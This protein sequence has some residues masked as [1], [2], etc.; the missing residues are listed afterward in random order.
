MSDTDWGI[1]VPAVSVSTK[2]RQTREMKRQG[3]DV[4]MYSVLG[5]RP[6]QQ[7]AGTFEWNG[8]MLLAAVCDGM[9]GMEGGEQASRIG[10][11]T[12]RA[13][14]EEQPPSCAQEG[15]EWMRRAFA[16]ADARI[17][18]LVNH[19]GER[20]YAGSTVVAVLAGE[21]R[22]QWGCVGDSRI[23]LMRNGRM[24]V[25]TR[26]H[27]YHLRLEEMF[28]R[29]E[30]DREEKDREAV[31]GEALISYLGIGGLPLIDT[32]RV[33]IALQPEDVILLCSDGLYKTLDDEQI[34]VIIEESGENMDI[35]A[36]RLCQE[37]CRLAVR[38][39]DNTTVIVVRYAGEDAEVTMEE[40]Q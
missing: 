32:A 28:Q 17:A 14:M 19:L 16:D 25:L 4:G 29:G 38:R 24:D 2:E 8:G 3:L 13:W 33:P 9:G 35:A 22:M 36:R 11:D 1:S 26:M 30:I 31:R 23:Y 10:I 40:K 34:Q 37:A 15:A 21:G 20:M 39:Q 6:T 7:D 27:N 5:E 12:L 18:S